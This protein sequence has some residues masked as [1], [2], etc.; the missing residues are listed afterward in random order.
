MVLHRPKTIRYHEFT[1]DPGGHN[2]I[3]TTRSTMRPMQVT[4]FYPGTAHA[5]FQPNLTRVL[6]GA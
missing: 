5:Q 6:K 3:K 4:Q 1:L 2:L